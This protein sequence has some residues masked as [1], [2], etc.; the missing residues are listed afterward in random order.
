[1]FFRAWIST[2]ASLAHATPVS[3]A[4]AF[5]VAWQLAQVVSSETGTTV[6]TDARSLLVDLSNAATRIKG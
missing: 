5:P 6:S 3:L 2:S 1:M 4:A